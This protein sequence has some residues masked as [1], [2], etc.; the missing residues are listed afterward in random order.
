MSGLGCQVVELV[1][2]LRP[3]LVEEEP[4]HCRKPAETVFLGY[5]LCDWCAESIEGL[6]IDE[7]D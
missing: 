3:E 4:T 5:R 1:T 7:R 2:I 6:L